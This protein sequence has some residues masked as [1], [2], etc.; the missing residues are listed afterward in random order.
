MKRKMSWNNRRNINELNKRTRTSDWLETNYS[1]YNNK[2]KIKKIKSTKCG[3]S[4]DAKQ[5]T[6]LSN[7]DSE[8]LS[9]K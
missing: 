7:A 6:S 8:D 9:T 3:T 1:E 2:K 4:G 5:N